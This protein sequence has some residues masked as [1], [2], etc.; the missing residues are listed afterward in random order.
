MSTIGRNSL[1]PC[2]SGKKYKHCCLGQ[3]E[4]AQSP[5]GRL[6]HVRH[7]TERPLAQ[8]I[9]QQFERKR[10]DSWMV[11]ALRDLAAVEP[12][13]ES[14]FA[15]LIPC[16]IYQ[17]PLGDQTPAAAFLAERGT[18]LTEFE[19]STLECNISGR[20]S[21]WE[22]RRVEPGEGLE[23]F[24]LLTH[25]TRFVHDV[26]GSQEAQR[27]MVML[28]IVVDY[29]EV[30]VLG[31]LHPRA[32]QPVESTEPLAAIR[33]LLGVR[34]RA[35]PADRLRAPA[36]QLAM[37]LQWRLAVADQLRR[38]MAPRIVSNTDGDPLVL[39]T[40]HFDVAVADQPHVLEL[41]AAIEGGQVESSDDGDVVVF[42]RAGNKTHKDWDNTVLGRARFKADRLL[43]ET[44]SVKRADSLRKDIERVAV[45]H[46]KYRLRDQLGAEAMMR[47]A[48]V[49]PEPRAKRP[50][51]SPEMQ[52]AMREMLERQYAT[53]VDTALPA[54][55]GHTPRAA[56]AST[57]L[58]PQVVALLKEFDYDERRK[59]E[60][61]RYDMSRLWTA[62]GLDPAGVAAGTTPSRAPAP[63]KRT[64]RPRATTAIF[65]L[66]VALRHV[67]PRIWRR[68]RIPGNTTLL[69]FHKV[70]Q[71]VMGWTD[72]HLHL[73]RA[74]GIEYGELDPE[75]PEIRTEKNVHLGSLLLR[76]GDRLVYEYDFGD[77]W[78]HDI[79]LD[80]TLSPDPG[81]GKYPYVLDGARACPPEDCGG[82]SGYEDLLR[83]LGD[84]RDPEH[85][86]SVLWVGGSFDPEE[87]DA[88]E[89]NRKFHRDW[90]L[91]D[92]GSPVSA[93]SE[94]ALPRLAPLSPGAPRRR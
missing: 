72:S 38:S 68:L 21:L 48:Q 32:L 35:V 91:P 9:L 71:K 45:A 77:S 86:D 7:G 54:L 30:S 50:E 20:M 63:V 75:L 26:L 58:R 19:R 52:A 66:T 90:S 67:E 34:T 74:G 60:Y 89:I 64:S 76:P 80:R 56:A 36:I 41:L 24:D 53:W 22:V 46:V 65:E 73:F 15:L 5:T 83:V 13:D 14:E 69:A 57:K 39:C 85:N 92:A 31:G 62:L 37:I 78:E 94:T 61:E 16:F 1:C 17:L 29:P 10:G 47:E 6:A 82:V 4:P 79:E 2:G 8:A 33:R 93:R 12:F 11:A 51:P 23:L 84:P 28:A 42:L 27:W 88:R 44:N 18:R 25:E 3:A 59:P 70:L 49:R 81:P 40:D 43:V 55:G 87:F